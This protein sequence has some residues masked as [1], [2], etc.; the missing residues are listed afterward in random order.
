MRG[1]L[2]TVSA[3]GKTVTPYLDINDPKWGV[4]VQSQ[5]RERGVQSITLHPQ[6]AQAGT[7]GFGKLYTFTDTSNMTPQPDFTTP[8]EKPTHDTG[9]ARVDGEDARRGHL[10]RRRRRESSSACASRSPITTA[11]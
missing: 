1:P 10:R 2:Y 11:G 3:D 7:P 5:G 4:P 6:F 8:S 9:A